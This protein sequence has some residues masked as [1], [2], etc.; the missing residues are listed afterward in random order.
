MKLLSGFGDEPLFKLLRARI[1]QPGDVDTFADRISALQR[2]SDF[3]VFVLFSRNWKITNAVRLARRLADVRPK[4]AVLCEKEWGADPRNLEP[5]SGFD[6]DL[7]DFAPEQISARIES[8]LER[9]RPGRRFIDAAQGLSLLAE[10]PEAED[11]ADRELAGD[12]EYLSCLDGDQFIASVGL[13]TSAMPSVE[14]LM[15]GGGR[16]GWE[17]EIDPA[18]NI[19]VA[20]GVISAMRRL[21]EQGYGLEDED[22]GSA[23]PGGSSSQPGSSQSRHNKP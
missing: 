7:V 1:E 6:L 15:T 22:L 12:D 20:P 2:G 4:S 3:F 21:A 10:N 14:E 16:R 13:R 18:D 11:R 9:L 19:D 23:L 8:R 5:F 17:P